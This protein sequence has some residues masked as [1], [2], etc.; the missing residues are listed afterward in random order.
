MYMINELFSYFIYIYFLVFITV[1]FPPTPFRAFLL[2][3]YVIICS[4]QICNKK[5]C[6]LLTLSA[7]VIYIFIYTCICVASY[8]F[9][10]YVYFSKVQWILWFTPILYFIT[11]KTFLYMMGCDLLSN[12]HFAMNFLSP[13][14]KMN[15]TFIQI[16]VFYAFLSYVIGPAIGYYA[17]GHTL[18]SAGNGFIVGSII[19]VLLWHFFGSK[20][21]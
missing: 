18:K 8:Y 4:I 14:N 9:A 17:F 1:Q 11:V 15:T 7:K 19:S 13:I 10:H 20:M 21:V 12:Y 5:N 2:A 3:L 16:M 6:P